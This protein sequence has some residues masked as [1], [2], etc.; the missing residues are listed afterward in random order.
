[1]R[2]RSRLVVASHNRAKAAE[3]QRILFGEGLEF[4][5]VSL[6]DFPEVTLPA[7]T[8][9]TFAENALLKA[10]HAA[11][12]TRL[13]AVADDSGLEVDALNGEPGIRSA[14]YV[15]EDATDQDRCEKV[16]T[17]LRD[18]PDDRR[19]ARFRCAAACAEPSGVTLLAEGTCEG[20]IAHEPRGFGG[21]G[22]DPI[23]VPE[24][25]SR[26][27]A[28]LTPEEKHAISHRGRAFRELAR[29]LRE[30]VA[31]ENG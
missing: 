26:T 20:R 6:A 25:E 13:P 1:M 18:T 5:V 27:M 16:L 24:G 8:G 9:R 10:A 28:Q 30:R 31:Q 12:A 3:I 19:T 22:Y 23:F 2:Q 14:R 29:L 21:F 7:E 17:L 4:E 11:E 15:G